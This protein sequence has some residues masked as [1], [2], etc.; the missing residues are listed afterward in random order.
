MRLPGFGVGGFKKG[1]VT[2]LR[3]VAAAQVKRVVRR[4]PRSLASTPR[5]PWKPRFDADSSVPL[6]DPLK[7]LLSRLG[8]T[9]ARLGKIEPLPQY[10]VPAKVRELSEERC[11]HFEG[12]RNEQAPPRLAA[13][14]KDQYETSFE[15]A[16]NAAK[17]WARDERR[18][19]L[20]NLHERRETM[21]LE[22]S[23]RR[24]AATRWLS[25]S[26]P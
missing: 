17:H 25:G 1:K 19:F 5:K 21:P 22:G 3:A 10:W 14:G 11:V 15:I 7:D 26:A 8:K 18:V 24:R 4:S 23:S 12:R 6:E 9:G 13:I 20:E 2:R 16:A